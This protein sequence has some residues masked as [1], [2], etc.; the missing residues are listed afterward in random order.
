MPR[1]KLVIEYAGTNYA[2][3][4]CQAGLPTIQGSLELAF[5]KVMSEHT[6]VTGGGRTDAGVHALGQVAHV[7]LAK[8]WDPFVIQQAINHHLKPEPITVIR[9]EAVDD[10]FHAR[11]SATH[12]AY[13]YQIINRYA[14]LALDQNRAWHIPGQQLELAPMQEAATYLLGTHDFSAFR[15]KECQAA[16]P[17]KTLDRLDITAEG[18]R[19]HFHVEARSFLHHQ[20]RNFVGTLKLVGSLKL[21]PLD[22]KNILASKDR[23]LAGPTAPASGLY[24]LRIDYEKAP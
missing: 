23:R 3:W 21:K 8:S 11:F 14:P 2:G 20:V 22:V 16:S 1:Y 9:V 13:R 5:L 15:A 24:F 12:R 4:Q 10:T 19:F 7:D 17:I 6:P 18:D